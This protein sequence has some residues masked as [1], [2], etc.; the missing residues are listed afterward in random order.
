MMNYKL[1]IIAMI[2]T[3]NAVYGEDTTTAA[4]PPTET[5]SRTT[6]TT[7]ASPIPKPPKPQSS[8]IMSQITDPFASLL[9]TFATAFQNRP[10]S[11]LFNRGSRSIHQENRQMLHPNEVDTDKQF[12]R[13]AREVPDNTKD[14]RSPPVNVFLHPIL[15][16]FPQLPVPAK[17]PED[18]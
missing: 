16:Q 3:L 15:P 12:N 8:S 17:K 2:L 5:T 7:P 13:M 1:V 9:N 11:S 4:T 18:E 10:V 6:S 14:V